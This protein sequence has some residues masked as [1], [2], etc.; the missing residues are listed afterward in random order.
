MLFYC[1]ESL[2]NGLLGGLLDRYIQ[3]IIGLYSGYNLSVRFHYRKSLKAKL[4]F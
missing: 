1:Y 3:A 4:A 2:C